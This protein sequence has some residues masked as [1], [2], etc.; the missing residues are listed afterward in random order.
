VYQAAKENIRAAITA[1][2]V[3]LG[4]RFFTSGISGSLVQSFRRATPAWLATLIV[5]ISLPIFSH[6]IEYVTHYV[7]ETYFAGVLPASANNGRQWAFAFSVLFSALSAMFNL[8]AMRHGVLLVGAGKETKSLW[9]DFKKIPALILEFVTYLP[10]LIIRF[11]G[12]AKFAHA[13]G[14]I[15]A[16]A[17]VIG[18]LLGIFRGKWSWAWTTSIGA[19]VTLLVWTVIVAIGMRVL[20]ISTKQNVADTA[21]PSNAGE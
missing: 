10:L 14:L 15:V 12:E 4:F 2:A 21:E 9:S 17:L 1:A 20:K 6:S 16:F 13:A 7:Q 18:S 19:F 5:T 11:V 3:E 8:F